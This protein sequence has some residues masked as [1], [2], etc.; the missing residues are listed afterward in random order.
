MIVQLL[1]HCVS[2]FSRVL[3]RLTDAKQNRRIAGTDRQKHLLLR[4]LLRALFTHFDQPLQQLIFQLQRSYVRAVDVYFSAINVTLERVRATEEL[5]KNQQHDDK[6]K[7]SSL[8]ASNR[9]MEYLRVV[10]NDSP[11]I[12]R[13]LG[14]LTSVEQFERSLIPFPEPMVRERGGLFKR[15]YP[16]FEL[17]CDLDEK[18]LAVLT[19]FQK[20][21]LYTT[22]VGKLHDNVPTL[23]FVLSIVLKA[24]EYH[25]QPH[26][27]AHKLHEVW[28][29]VYNLAINMFYQWLIALH[30]EDIQTLFGSLL[31][32]FAAF[33]EKLPQLVAQMREDLLL[34]NPATTVAGSR[35]RPIDDDDDEKVGGHAPPPPPPSH[36]R[37]RRLA[38]AS[39]T[40]HDK[41]S[42]TS[43][44]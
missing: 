9:I 11:E 20:E 39:L 18:L 23:K 41:P 28:N 38:A 26:V 3:D 22:V 40:K 37:P 17:S 19:R 14:C 16:P 24:L 4:V 12:V 36:S 10:F 31:K 5:P 35:K 8:A 15:L 43:F 27:I 30:P 2:V 34:A 1:S 21:D 29:D 33:N 25:Q 13:L 42:S 7:L 32:K 44:K 6:D